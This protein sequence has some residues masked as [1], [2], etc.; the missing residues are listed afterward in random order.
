MVVFFFVIFRLIFFRA[1]SL[2]GKN[3][4]IIEIGAGVAIPTVRHHSEHYS[5]LWD[6]PLIRINPEHPQIDRASSL[7]KHVSITAGAEDALVRINQE[8]E[9]IGNK[10]KGK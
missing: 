5:R 8:M 7:Q 9:K 6:C 2:K 4:V 3:V 10:T 1:N